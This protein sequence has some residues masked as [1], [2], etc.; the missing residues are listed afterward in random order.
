MSA[1][2]LDPIRPELRDEAEARL[3]AGDW[4]RFRSLAPNTD[5]LDLVANNIQ[6]LRDRGLYEV[7]LLD[8]LTASRTNN[9][10]A[11][12]ILPWLVE[13]ADRARLR[14]AGDPLPGTGPFTLYRGV[15][16]H[17]SARRVHGF[18]WS[19]SRE[20]AQWFADRATCFGL[21]SPAVYRA[22]LPESRV[23]A[24]TDARTEQE[25]LVLL[26]RADKVERI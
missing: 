8:A 2:W 10:H 21:A 11:Y 15:G 9:R 17:G 18:S 14:A 22:V 26:N 1:L 6:P 7:A 19:M 20:R 4:V 13:M 24:Y 23:L 12:G 5:A 3:G 16:G 25:C